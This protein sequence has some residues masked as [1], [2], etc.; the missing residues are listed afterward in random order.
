MLNI[1]VS[2]YIYLPDTVQCRS[3]STKTV[4][5]F[6]NYSTVLGA[7]IRLQWKFKNCKNYIEY[8]FGLTRLLF[9]ILGQFCHQNAHCILCFLHVLLCFDWFWRV[10]HVFWHVLTFRFDDFCSSEFFKSGQMPSIFAQKCPT[11]INFSDHCCQ[12]DK[13]YHYFFDIT[14]FDNFFNNFE[15]FSRSSQMPSILAQKCPTCIAFSDRCCQEDNGYRLFEEFIEA[16]L[17]YCVWDQSSSDALYS[18]R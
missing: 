12:E 14:S 1:D 7:A 13:D 2:V 6:Y 15:F 4:Q 11:C 10:F 18:L 16:N 9:W 5:Q 3:Y 8:L 17:H